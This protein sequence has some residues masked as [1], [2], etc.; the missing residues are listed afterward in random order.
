MANQKNKRT[1]R[2]GKVTYNIVKH[3]G[4][5]AKYKSGWTKELNIV[6]W[7][8]GPPKYDLRDWDNEHENMGKGLT[9]VKSEARE[10]ARLLEESFDLEDIDK[11]PE[12]IDKMI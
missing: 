6:E 4:V 9:F 1:D 7:N 3:I 5:V 11:I 10:L 2:F 12:K 8:D